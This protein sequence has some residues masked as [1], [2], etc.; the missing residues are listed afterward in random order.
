MQ[1]KYEYENV[2]H[3]FTTFFRLKHKHC[4]FGTLTFIL[5]KL[6]VFIQSCPLLGIATSVQQNIKSYHYLQFNDYFFYRYSVSVKEVR[7]LILQI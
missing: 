2:S 3:T 1:N 5:K 6:K 7:L 4:K